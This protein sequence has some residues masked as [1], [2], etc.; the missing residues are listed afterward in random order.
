MAEIIITIK[1]DG[2][3]LVDVQGWEGP[4]CSLLSEP[5]RKALGTDADNTPKPEFYTETH[6]EATL[7]AQ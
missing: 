7:E 3:P 6:Q 5:F 1:P 2:T 4:S